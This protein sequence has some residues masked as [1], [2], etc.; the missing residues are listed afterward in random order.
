MSIE[1]DV[2]LRLTTDP[3]QDVSPAWSPDGSEL[4]FHTAG[5]IYIVR[6]NGS[7][8][9]RISEDGGQPSWSPDGSRIAFTRGGE[10]FTMALD[11]SGVTM[12]EGVV[13]VP[14]YAWV[15]NPVG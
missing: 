11:G 12:L 8:L 3:A 13:V 15:W 2:P 9:H 7:G 6:A 14:N 10:L 4:A 5:G 1:A